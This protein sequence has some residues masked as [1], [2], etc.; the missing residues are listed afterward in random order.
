VRARTCEKAFQKHMSETSFQK[1]T[2]EKSLEEHTCRKLFI[3]TRAK[4]DFKSKNV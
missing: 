4:S 2:C 1:L 3:S